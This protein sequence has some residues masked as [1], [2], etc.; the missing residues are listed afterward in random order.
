MILKFDLQFFGGGGGYDITQIPKRKEEP[1]ELT[2]LRNNVL[3]HINTSLEAFDSN[4]WNK[5]RD[6]TNNSLNQQNSLMARIP[7]HL[8]QNNTILNNMLNIANTG[9][10][11]AAIT[12]KLTSG[13][14]K[15]LQGSMG[16]LLNN[17][18]SRGAVNSSITGQGISR[19]GQQAAEAFNN[20]YLNAFNSVLAG[21]AQA[22]NGSQNN[23]S[24]T[25]SALGKVSGMGANAYADAAAGLMPAYNMWKDFQKSYDSRED[26]DTIATQESSSCIT[27]D[28]L[29]TLRDGSLVPVSELHDYDCICAWDFDYGNVIS[30]PLTAFFKRVHHKPV[31]V[32]RLIF[33]DGSDVGVILEHLFFDFNERKFVAVNAQ[34]DYLIG[35]HFARVDSEGNVKPVKLVEIIRDEK[36]TESFAPQCKGHLNFLANGFIS[37]NDGQLPFCNMFEFNHHDMTFNQKLKQADIRLHGFLDYSELQDFVSEQFF[38]DNNLSIFNVAIDKGLTSL[39][40]IKSYLSKF[41]HC[42]LKGE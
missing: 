21:Q 12:D 11:P 26:Y 28:T 20:N 10:L 3:G 19:L 40:Y 2:N 14:T 15:Q 17:M 37:G 16:S 35:H 38:F 36:A 32:I 9:E 4:T 31:D 25:L 23:L 34:A 6:I 33:E 8:D 42:F 1:R 22:L 13:V 24:S 18:A 41:N 7:G 30:A 5:A 27:G 39:D 29:V